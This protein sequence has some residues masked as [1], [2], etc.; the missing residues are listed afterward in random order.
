M[1]FRR[2]APNDVNRNRQ[3]KRRHDDDSRYVL[4]F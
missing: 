4:N 1:I 3:L 2:E